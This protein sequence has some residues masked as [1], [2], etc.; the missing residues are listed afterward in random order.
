M[1]GPQRRGSNYGAKEGSRKKV[2]LELYSNNW[3]E[4]IRQEERTRKS[5]EEDRMPTYTASSCRAS[6]HELGRSRRQ[7]YVRS[8]RSTKKI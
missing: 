7:G 2:T 5:P 6:W 1:T 4:L 8:L 3:Q